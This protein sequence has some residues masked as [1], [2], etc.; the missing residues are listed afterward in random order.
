MKCYGP[1]VSEEILD[2]RFTQCQTAVFNGKITLAFFHLSTMQEKSAS[3]TGSG[4]TEESS[5]RVH[6]LQRIKEIPSSKSMI[7]YF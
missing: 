6:H 5:A 2:A 4:A 7:C 1:A 3:L